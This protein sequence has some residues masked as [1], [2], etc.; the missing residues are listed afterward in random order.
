MTTEKI[1]NIN[2]FKL[3]VIKDSL[4]SI[5]DE[6]FIALAK[7]SMSPMFYEALD[8]ACG[9]TDRKGNLISQGN[10]VTSFIGMLSPMV[11]HVIEKYDDGKQLQDGDVIII[12]DPYVGG[13]SHLSDVGLVM[14][15][16]YED[17]LVA[18]SVNKGHW[19][20]VGGK[21]PG[22]FTNDSTEIFQEGLQLP[23]VKLFEAN[24]MNQAVLDIIEMNVR[25]PKQSLGDMWAQ[26][27]AL[28]TGKN[29]FI[30]LCE[31]HTKQYVVESINFLL[32]QGKILSKQALEKLPKGTFEATDFIED[33][34]NVGGP[35]PINA[36]I[37]I[38]DDEFICDFRGSANQVQSPV[39]C[40]YYGLM[41]SVRVM[42]L[43]IIHPTKI[44]N[45]GVFEPLKIITD[46]G[47][48][49]SAERPAPV[50]MNFEGRLGGADLIWKALAPHIPNQL[51]AGH[52]LSVSSVIVSGNH[53]DKDEPFLLVEP[54]VGGWGAGN[55]QDGQRGQFCMGDGETYNIPI[56][57]A[58]A[59]Y[60]VLV[61]EY[62]LRCDS[63]GSGKYIGGSGVVRKY[64]ALSDHQQLS[65]S[66][67]RHQHA[68]WGV[69]G[70][71]EGGKSYIKILRK[72][73]SVEGPTG[74]VKTLPFHKGD[75]V[76]L[77]TA[78]GGGYGNPEERPLEQV[79]QDVKNGYISY[80]DAKNIYK[81]EL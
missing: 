19:T 38:T 37:T 64:K 76:E 36:K 55:D 7:T 32:E 62:A 26:I 28:R 68:P 61:E 23:G 81:K 72:D 59:R 27:A 78:T 79:K 24:E 31:K 69:N 34:P 16:F 74:I 10:G 46:Q 67:G 29:R 42:Y 51:P 44:I 21:D 1:D 4:L 75:V 70:G 52:L 5:G 25:L 56:E 58:E 40:S 30:E 54:S 60:G 15:I 71:N 17:E 33:D 66:F 47:S 63:G 22:S 49:L 80:E 73:G 13:G 53:P 11:Q 77:A 9:L 50:S 3:E 43:A 18:F 41:A 45:E 20:E 35:Y 6:M 8:Y 48:I 14:P 2:P 39:N 12:N 57:I 65:V